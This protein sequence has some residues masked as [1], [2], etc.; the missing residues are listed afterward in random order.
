MAAGSR[1]IF[2]LPSWDKQ[3]GSNFAF[4]ECSENRPAIAGRMKEFGYDLKVCFNPQTF[5]G[6]KQ[7]V[8]E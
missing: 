2:L 8:D 7:G 3:M 5:R 1:L 4:A 6:K